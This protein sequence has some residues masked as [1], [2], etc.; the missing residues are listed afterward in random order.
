MQKRKLLS[1]LLTVALVLQLLGAAI[2]ANAL[3]GSDFPADEDME[4][5][6]SENFE[7]A[8]GKDDYGIL[9][10]DTHF[11]YIDHSPEHTLDT[12]VPIDGSKSVKFD[13]TGG[14]HE[15]N[16]L[17]TKEG[18][19]T[20]GKF[21]TFTEEIKFNG[22]MPA[23]FRLIL[24]S[25]TWTGSANWP[26]QL[27]FN[28]VNGEL[29]A[30]DTALHSHYSADTYIKPIAEV[31]KLGEGHYKII[32]KFV[33]I[34]NTEGANTVMLFNSVCGSGDFSISYDNLCI[35]TE[36]ESTGDDEVEEDSTFPADSDMQ[37]AFAGDFNSLTG[38][39]TYAAYGTDLHFPYPQEGHSVETE[40]PIE[41][42]AS[43]KYSYTGTDYANSKNS[44]GMKEGN[45]SN[46]KFTKFTQEIKFEGSIPADFKF[47][48]NTLTWNG[49]A[50]W[51]M[52]LYYTVSNGE[53]VAGETSLNAAYSPDEYIKP[54]AEVEKLGE[55]HY[56][57]IA[58]FMGI[59]DTNGNNTVMLFNTYS[60]TGPF[61][62]INDNWCLY[63]EKEPQP[64][65]VYPENL[66]AV[67]SE[68]FENVV[69]P[70][71]AGSNVIEGSTRGLWYRWNLDEATAA[72]Y[73]IADV[74]N[75]ST[76]NSVI[77][78]NKSYLVNKTVGGGVQ[79]FC[80]EPTFVNDDTYVLTYKL[81]ANELPDD[82]TYSFTAMRWEAPNYFFTY[83]FS[84]ADGKL[85]GALAERN[86]SIYTDEDVAPEAVIKDMGDY[87]SI[88]LKFTGK[89]GMFFY[90]E[91][92]GSACSY[93]VDD[94]NFYKAEKNWNVGS[95]VE[96]TKGTIFHEKF[97]KATVVEEAAITGANGFFSAWVGLNGTYSVTSDEAEVVDG[98][99]SILYDGTG[100]NEFLCFGQGIT[101][102]DKDYKLLLKVKPIEPITN[103]TQI[104]LHNMSY[105]T[106]GPN[107]DN[108]LFSATYTY[109]AANDE[110]V[111]SYNINS[112]TIY[113]KAAPRGTAAFDEN[114]ILNIGL[115]FTDSLDALGKNNNNW[116][117]LK[118]VGD[119]KL[120]ID[121]VRYIE[122][123]LY[124]GVSRYFEIE[125]E[126]TGED[127]DTNVYYKETATP[128]Y[129]E[130]FESATELTDDGVAGTE[131]EFPIEGL[132]DYHYLAGQDDM[133]ASHTIEGNKSL[134]IM[135]AGALTNSVEIPTSYGYGQYYLYTF[136]I[137]ANT[138]ELDEA[139][140]NNFD[141][142]VYGHTLNGTKDTFFEVK[143]S[144]EAGVITGAEVTTTDA[145]PFEAP[146]CKYV[147]DENGVTT[148]VI[149]FRGGKS[150]DGEPTMKLRTAFAGD[151][152]IFSIDELA[153]YKSSS[154]TAVENF[155]PTTGTVVFTEDF[156]NAT[157]I[158]DSNVEGAN[159]WDVYGGMDAEFAVLPYYSQAIS[160]AKSLRYTSAVDNNQNLALGNNDALRFMDGTDYKLLF[161]LSL[162]KAIADGT[163]VK[164]H[165]RAWEG[166]TYLFTVKY[167][168]I[169]ATDSWV[170]S[171][172]VDNAT[173]YA[174]SAPIGF[175]TKAEGADYYDFGLSFTGATTSL[176]NDG[177]TF[178]AF[179]FTGDVD[180]LI[181]DI[182]IVEAPLGESA[183]RYFEA[184][185]EKAVVE[186]DVDDNGVFNA[187]DLVVLRKYLLG[188]DEMVTDYA[189]ANADANGD[190]K[191]N[192]RDL[193]NLKKKIA[194]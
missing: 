163:T 81:K 126:D 72:Y 28:T 64:I 172:N 178:L 156:E 112:T 50:N 9:G 34:P 146:E 153:V 91:T 162:E 175:V 166:N 120:A 13:I 62:V 103:G 85:V 158:S 32:A 71:P 41:G 191:I 95:F 139:P 102:N 60:G 145:Y 45:I 49:T 161:K 127:Y 116:F 164:I 17:G 73:S 188:N 169:A 160:G 39:D 16:S 66:T 4:L 65:D 140:E 7:N 176:G 115:S 104:T 123:P 157:G 167:T 150:T 174:K 30:G 97:E 148:V 92:A 90:T 113:P 63:T 75:P 101:Y 168:Y 23:D 31:E 22:A 6:W 141:Y 25:L 99:K 121:N 107:S 61:T 108:Y 89:E 144:A 87:Y 125:E 80:L 40:S 170:A 152:A 136:K 177:I 184:F 165:Y 43:L 57:I 51:P 189:S 142:T 70:C 129:S 21:T 56:K 18:V 36:K 77:G 124:E 24:N 179:E 26:M 19:L 12:T 47:C 20:P 117:R 79:S 76:K 135:A 58:K 52:Q 128:L 27:Y 122:A 109:S 10:T 134:G 171:T 151:Y 94:F 68:N 106:T 100:T 14:A 131:L 1:L 53:L 186:G 130:N 185:E 118:L 33:A 149:K 42:S 147:T 15:F 46:G 44:I 69:S 190:G 98:G 105:S 192:I 54:I 154:V 183:G 133:F 84:M 78:G 59:G 119:L 5:T 11:P 86:A 111:F 159:V 110:W 114:G 37:L 82:F 182:A 180:M 8:T 181:D 3:T 137:K 132:M 138:T 35:Y 143:L 38:V 194:K 67:W 74:A 93:S 155:L 96:K 48:V 187:A 193:V 88:A 173:D 83:R 55:G 2:T 29:V